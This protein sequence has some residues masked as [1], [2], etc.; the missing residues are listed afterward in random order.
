MRILGIDPGFE[1]L[2][3]AILEKEKRGKERVP[4]EPTTVWVDKSHSFIAR[5]FAERARRFI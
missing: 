5:S 3:V 2:G 4:F 1:R